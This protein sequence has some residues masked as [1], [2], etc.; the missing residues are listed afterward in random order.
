MAGGLLGRQ[1]HNS[2][3]SCVD[4]W[5]VAVDEAQHTTHKLGDLRLLV[6]GVSRHLGPERTRCI[7]TL[8]FS[9]WA[10]RHQRGFFTYTKALGTSLGYFSSAEYS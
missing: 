1:R 4:A 7:E 5:L 8:H 6:E 9:I 2:Q 10:S 3:D